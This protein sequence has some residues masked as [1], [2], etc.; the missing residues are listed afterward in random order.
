MYECVCMHE[1]VWVYAYVHVYTYVYVYVCMYVWIDAWTCRE[2]GAQF[3]C[4][5]FKWFSLSPISVGMRIW[6][7][8]HMN[9]RICVHTYVCVYSHII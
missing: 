9:I 1:Y 4:I 5:F 3:E 2:Q 6:V 8:E 7:Y